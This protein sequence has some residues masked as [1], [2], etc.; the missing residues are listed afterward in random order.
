MSAIQ[1]DKEKKRQEIAKE[2]QRDRDKRLQQMQLK[3]IQDHEDLQRK[4]IQKQQV[5]MIVSGSFTFILMLYFHEG[6]CYKT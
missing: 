4:I 3:E 1:E 2:K 5:W 6:I